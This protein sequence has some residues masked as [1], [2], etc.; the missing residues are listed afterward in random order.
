MLRKRNTE[1]NRGADYI[2]SLEEC[3]NLI[4]MEQDLDRILDADKIAEIINTYLQAAPGRHRQIFID[5]FYLGRS[6]KETAEHLGVSLATVKRELGKMRQN[7]KRLLEKEG[8]D[9]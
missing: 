1:R 9:L 5:R 2:I 8:I 7:L 6:L 3:E 4:G